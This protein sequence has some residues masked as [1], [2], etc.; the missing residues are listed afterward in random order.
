MSD[1]PGCEE[2]RALAPEL[3]LGIAVG[4][5]R[6]R[7]LG[8]LVACPACRRHL[9]ELS[10]VADDLLLL[11]PTQEPAVGFESR[12]L[13]ELEERPERPE[14]RRRRPLVAVAA[15]AAAVAA[16]LVTASAMWLAFDDDRDLADRYRETLA[17]ANGKYLTAEPLAAAG[18]RRAGTVFGYEGEP[19]WVLVTVYESARPEPGEYELQVITGKGRRVDLR[20]MWIYRKG[21]SGGSAI[22]IHFHDVT[23][24]RLIGP[25]RGNVLHASFGS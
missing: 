1:R 17:V 4:D 15:A 12:V 20:P 5:E 19:S 6:A 11:A 3:A 2:V 25:G 7:V 14:R 18:G 23:E 9:E 13:D 21:G 22:P 24:V 16:A 10:N 8:H